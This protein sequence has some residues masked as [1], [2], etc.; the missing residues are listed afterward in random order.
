VHLEK[1]SW[2]DVSELASSVTAMAGDGRFRYLYA[3]PGAAAELADKARALVG[4]R[5]WVW[6]RR[7]LLE[8]GMLGDGATGSIP[9]RLGDVVLGAKEPVAFIDPSMANEPNLKSGHGSLTADEML[10]PL[11]AARGTA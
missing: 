3:R 4:D 5:G 1:Q 10:V 11:V 6:T 9:G 2:I 7:E 8:S